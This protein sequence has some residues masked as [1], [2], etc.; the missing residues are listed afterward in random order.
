MTTAACLGA[1]VMSVLLMSQPAW[2]Q[3]V[4]PPAYAQAAAQAQIPPTVLYAVALQESGMAWR[5]R[6]V[7][8]P[9]TLNIAGAP[10][11]FQTRASA[12]AALRF[13]IESIPSKRIDVGLGQVNLGYHTQR[14]N[15]PCE[16]LNPYRNL[17]VTADI[18]R[19]QRAP[20]EDW[21]PAIGRYHRPAGGVPAQQYRQSVNRHLL[22][23][24]KATTTSAKP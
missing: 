7:P 11:R 9:W 24:Q 17:A 12:C 6:L 16:L 19:E 23:M 18:L 21:L 14:Y 20:G 8:W 10:R 1:L 2:S 22:R 13:A 15:S 3:A 5:G 4:P